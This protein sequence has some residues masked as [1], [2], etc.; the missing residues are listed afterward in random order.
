MAQEAAI[1]TC[2]AMQAYRPSRGCARC[3][4][5]W[6]SPP[7]GHR[8]PGPAAEAAWQGTATVGAYRHTALGRGQLG[9]ATGPHGLI[10]R[11]VSAPEGSPPLVGS[12]CD[13]SRRRR[14]VRLLAAF[15]GGAAA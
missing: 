11:H 12:A 15:I 13:V 3:G 6:S 4:F 1:G 2:C 10:G 7:T 5:C 14:A 8:D 9:D